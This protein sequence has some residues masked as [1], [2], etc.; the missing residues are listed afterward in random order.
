MNK[1]FSIN[2][3]VIIITGGSG[4]IGNELSNKMSEQ[5][6]IIYSIDKQ[7]SKNKKQKSKVIHK[8]C[9]ILNK[10]QL[11]NICKDIFKK[12]KK[13]DVLIN[14]AGITKSGKD[15][16]EYNESNWKE[17]LD[18]NLT[19]SF[20]TS[21]SV[22]KYMKK[23]KSGSII[24]I[25]SINA[26][27]G[28]P[29]NPAYVASKGGLKMLSKALAK[30]YGK[31]GIRVNNLGPGYI[32]TGMVKTSYE[33][34]KEHSLREK[35]TILGIWGTVEDLVGPCIFLS[36]NASNYITGQDIYVDGGWLANGLLT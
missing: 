15:G 14:C 6:A 12:H 28:F 34:K 22:I 2:N 33:N 5:G 20:L 23:S 8:K 10:N 9:N 31:F 3:K 13:I 24:N 16:T 11:Q 25:T 30:D 36:S 7:L 21:Q 19:G 29:N 4:G 27:L 1:L 35:H 17:T 32:G 26:E 18:V